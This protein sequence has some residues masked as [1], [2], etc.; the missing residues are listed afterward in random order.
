VVIAIIGVLIALLLPAVQ[1]AREAA[2]RMQCANHLK[3]IALACHNYESAHT[4]FPPSV[5]IS[6]ATGQY[7][8][9]V[10]ESFSA[11]GR[12]LSYMEQGQR[13]QSN[14]A[15]TS[16]K[17]LRHPAYTCPSEINNTART[18]SSGW[19]PINYGFNAGTWR[20]WTPSN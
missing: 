8:D 20:I 6:G 15:V 4:V 9:N 16:A 18:T 5:T 13:V 1:T 3:Q 17:S 7:T 19:Y 11:V 12:I 10:T 14:T 2:R